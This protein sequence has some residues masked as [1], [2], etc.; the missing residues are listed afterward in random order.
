MK[1]RTLC[2]ILAMLMVCVVVSGQALAE[3]KYVMK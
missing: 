3:A 2:L 1:R